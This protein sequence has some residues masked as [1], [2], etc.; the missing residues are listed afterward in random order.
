MIYHPDH[1]D[2]EKTKWRIPTYNRQ[3]LHSTDKIEYQLIRWSFNRSYHTGTALTVFRRARKWELG[4]AKR[5]KGSRGMRDVNLSSTE[6]GK[7]LGVERGKN[8]RRMK[9][10]KE[11]K[12][13]EGF[14]KKGKTDKEEAYR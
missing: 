7:E 11:G 4:E 2:H 1:E 12:E 5:G 8:A 9:M 13:D 14:W 3:P 10:M 6:Q